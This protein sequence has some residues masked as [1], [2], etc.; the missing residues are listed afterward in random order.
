MVSHELLRARPDKLGDRSSKQTGKILLGLRDEPLARDGRQIGYGRCIQQFPGGLANG[1]D[2][3][4][5]DRNEGCL[6][7]QQQ[8]FPAGV[9][10]QLETDT[11]QRKASH[12]LDGGCRPGADPADAETG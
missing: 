1:R 3:A 7:G 10:G 11:E 12:L 4:A 6:L 5:L 2:P 8:P 9:D